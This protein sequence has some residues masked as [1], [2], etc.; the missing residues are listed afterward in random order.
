[1]TIWNPAGSEKV[2]SIAN[3][4]RVT[5]LGIVFSTLILTPDVALSDDTTSLM[6]GSDSIYAEI[7][8]RPQRDETGTLEITAYDYKSEVK[9][10]AIT[11]ISIE[12]IASPQEQSS[13]VDYS[14]FLGWYIDKKT[15]TKELWIGV[16]LAP[17]SRTGTISFALPAMLRS[18][19]GLTNDLI[20]SINTK[21]AALPDYLDGTERSIVYAPVRRIEID[22]ENSG[23]TLETFAGCKKHGI[24]RLLWDSRSDKT[25]LVEAKFRWKGQYDDSIILFGT[26]LGGLLFGIF[27]SRHF[28]HPSLGNRL[29]LTSLLG[30]GIF[31]LPFITRHFHL[32]GD[33]S[34]LGFFWGLGP[35]IALGP[36]LGPKI[37][38]VLSKARASTS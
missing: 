21:C 6:P 18:P 38:S 23:L 4:I 36:I 8:I 10:L 31:L 15:P 25:D 34:V 2:I 28:L 35:G 11:A 24:G 27:F 19:G 20:L 3:S 1:M 14:Y 12:V 22:Y 29:I 33:T 9:R 13:E 5:T 30:L 37:F 17:N 26:L 7:V 16:E 32:I